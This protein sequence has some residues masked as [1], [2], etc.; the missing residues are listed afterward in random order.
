[1]ILKLFVLGLIYI[2]TTGERLVIL[3]LPGT[4]SDKE[5]NTFKFIQHAGDLL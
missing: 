2:F 1:M 4:G 5:E 3:H